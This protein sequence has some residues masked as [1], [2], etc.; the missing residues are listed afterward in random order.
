MSVL[1]AVSLAAIAGRLLLLSAVVG[2]PAWSSLL[3]ADTT[4]TKKP[5]L[6]EV[7]IDEEEIPDS[8]L[9]PRWKI[10]RTTALTIDDYRLPAADQSWARLAG[11]QPQS[12][13]REPERSPAW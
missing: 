4:K 12:W 7:I 2:E 11:W 1:F 8:L 3:P 5:D 10:Q 9:H 6:P 13:Q